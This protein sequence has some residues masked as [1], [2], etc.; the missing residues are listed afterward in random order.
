[1]IDGKSFQIGQKMEKCHHENLC[2]L[3]DEDTKAFNK[4][5]D[6]FALP[7][8]SDEEKALR[9]KAIENATRYAIEIP[10]RVMKA[11]LGSFKLI[12]AMANLE[13]QIQYQMRELELCVQ[14]RL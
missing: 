3:V 6:A 2:A 13:I 7:K 9:K 11:A 4:I 8:S 12:K 10:F 5:M 1:M 14:E